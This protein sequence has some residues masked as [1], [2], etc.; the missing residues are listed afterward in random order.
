MSLNVILKKVQKSWSYPNSTQKFHAI[1]FSKVHQNLEAILKVH[2]KSHKI[3]F[4]KVQE[5]FS[6]DP[7]SAQNSH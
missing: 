5:K 3:S 7:K 1:S 4:S 6:S 2:R